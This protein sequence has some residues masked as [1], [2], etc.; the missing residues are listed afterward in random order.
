MARVVVWLVTLCI[1][2]TRS[3]EDPTAVDSPFGDS[4]KALLH[5]LVRRVALIRSA[6]TIRPTVQG[7][8]AADNRLHSCNEED[9]QIFCASP[10]LS[11]GSMRTYNSTHQGGYQGLVRRCFPLLRGLEDYRVSPGA[12]SSANRTCAGA[13]TSDLCSQAVKSELIYSCYRSAR[14]HLLASTKNRKTPSVTT[15]SRDWSSLRPAL[16]IPCGQYDHSPVHTNPLASKLH[17]EERCAENLGAKWRRAVLTD[18]CARFPTA[19]VCAEVSAEVPASQRL[20]AASI[21]MYYRGSEDAFVS[22]STRFDT[23]AAL[24]APAWAPAWDACVCLKKCGKRHVDC[25]EAGSRYHAV[26]A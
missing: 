2:P 26:T 15:F 13:V 18:Q 12:M 17:C 10:I 24:Q 11:W 25:A 16:P 21:N 1:I 14:E 19:D 3:R 22:A 7:A 8:H 23:R 4:H 6:P 5:D 20:D 9:L